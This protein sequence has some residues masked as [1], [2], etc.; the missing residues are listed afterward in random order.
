[1]IVDLRDEM[2]ELALYTPEMIEKRVKVHDGDIIVLHTGWHRFGQ[3]GDTPD[4]ERYVHYHPGP[5]P[6]IVEWLLDRKIHVWGVER[7][8]DHPMNLRSGDSGKGMHGTA[9]ACGGGE[10]KLAG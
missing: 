2:D 6:D 9:I 7:S 8:R 10:K 4:E 3:F 5:H 1:M